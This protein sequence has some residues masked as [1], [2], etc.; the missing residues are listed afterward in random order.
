MSM[1][2]SP[3]LGGQV[4]EHLGA[5]VLWAICLAIGVVVAVGHLVAAPAR[6]G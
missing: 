4:I 6:A 5:P 1:G 3:I 2:A